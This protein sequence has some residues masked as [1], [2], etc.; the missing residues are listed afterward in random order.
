MARIRDFD[1]QIDN[2][3][4]LDI[5]LGHGDTA[6]YVLN[7]GLLQVPPVY[8][9]VVLGISGGIELMAQHQIKSQREEV[10]LIPDN[11]IFDPLNI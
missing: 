7:G 1:K 8:W 3:F 11:L 10:E 9:E 5:I 4:H 2:E 6:P